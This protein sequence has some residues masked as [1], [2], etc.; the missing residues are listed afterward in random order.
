MQLTIEAC[1]QGFPPKQYCDKDTLVIN[2]DS[3]LAPPQITYPGFTDNYLKIYVIRET[4]QTTDIIDTLIATDADTTVI[5]S[6]HLFMNNSHIQYMIFYGT[7]FDKKLKL[8]T[9]VSLPDQYLHL[10]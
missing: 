5:L 6:L 8:L 10:A 7:G 3:N 9:L 4:R 1:D 2:V